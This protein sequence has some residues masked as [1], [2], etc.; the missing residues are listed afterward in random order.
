MSRGNPAISEYKKDYWTDKVQPKLELVE[1]W[2]RNGLSNEQISLNLGISGNTFKKFIR[3]HEEL[4]EV[5]YRGREDANVLVENALFKRCIG[6]SYTEVT[7]ERCKVYDEDGKWTGQYEMRVTKKITKHI[8]P[9]VTAQKY[10]LEHR[11]PDRWATIAEDHSEVV[12][13]GFIDALKRAA[14]EVWEDGNGED[15]T[16]E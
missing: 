13:D 7:K 5:L 4:E 16:P 9:D 3:N 8:V 11:M 12:D 2:A 15:S 14:R 1:G 6:Y 10:W